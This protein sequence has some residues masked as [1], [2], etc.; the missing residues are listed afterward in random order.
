MFTQNLNIAVTTALM[1]PS[2]WGPF[3]WTMLHGLALVPRTAAAADLMVKFLTELQPLLPC[4][5]C[6]QS[7]RDILAKRSASLHA[8]VLAGTYM[9]WLFDLHRS[10]THKLLMEQYQ[11]ADI[12]PALIPALLK[13]HDDVAI[14]FEQVRARSVQNALC[15]PHV[16]YMCVGILL[17]C[18]QTVGTRRCVL[19]FLTTL[20]QVMG[21]VE[22]SERNFEGVRSR[23][24]RAILSVGEM[25]SVSKT[26]RAF[27]EEMLG[28]GYEP[29]ARYIIQLGTPKGTT[30]SVP[31]SGSSPWLGQGSGSASGSGSGSGLG[32][33]APKPKPKP[34]QLLRKAGHGRK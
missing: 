26:V 15:T 2:L 3:V 12:D 8:A 24:H 9:R 4:K 13:A 7:F 33:G 6:R 5:V 32:L 19:Q 20:C 27:G 18:A 16:L 17:C 10:V 31:E 14:T 1:H 29:T 22:D 25:D 21:E 30:T 28:P 11:D 34:A 23:L